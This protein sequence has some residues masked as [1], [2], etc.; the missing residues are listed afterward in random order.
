VIPNNIN[1]MTINLSAPV[2]I[3]VRN[4][5]GCQIILDDRK[6]RVRTPVSELLGKSV[7]DGM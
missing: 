2:I 6:Y 7:K 4:K 3:N 1:A 5:K